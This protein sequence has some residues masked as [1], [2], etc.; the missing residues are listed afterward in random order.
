[1]K[2]EK[3]KQ[4]EID[5]ILVIFNEDGMLLRP[6]IKRVGDKLVRG[7]LCIH[8]DRSKDH[9]IPAEEVGEIDDT[10]VG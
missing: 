4:I 5:G 2:Q 9:F 7:V 1:M 8:K 6:V 3:F 10:R